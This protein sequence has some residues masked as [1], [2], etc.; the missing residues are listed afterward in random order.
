MLKGFLMRNG[1]S[2]LHATWLHGNRHPIWEECDRVDQLLVVNCF[3]SAAGW[4]VLETS[5]RAVLAK[6]P[7]AEIYLYLSMEGMGEVGGASLIDAIFGFLAC[8]SQISVDPRAT[9]QVWIVCDARRG[10][11]HPKGYALKAGSR[12]ITVVGSSNTTRAGQ[13]ENYEMEAQLSDPASFIDFVRA[14]EELK[15]SGTARR[16]NI[17]SSEQLRRFAGDKEQ[18]RRAFARIAGQAGFDNQRERAIRELQ[19]GPSSAVPLAVDLAKTL[20]DVRRAFRVGLRLIPHDMGIPTH[21]VSLQ[22]FVKAG[23]LA[24]PSPRDLHAGIMVSSQKRSPSVSANLAPGAIVDKIKRIKHRQAAVLGLFSI[25]MLGFR[26][27]PC[28]WEP[29]FKAHLEVCRASVGEIALEDVERH[30]KDISE[31]L[32][33]SDF[34]QRLATALPIVRNTARWNVE[35]INET[36]HA[37]VLMS[38]AKAPILLGKEDLYIVYGAI[39]DHV[40]A[41]VTDHLDI[42]HTRFQVEM[43]GAPPRSDDPPDLGRNDALD[44][45]ATMSELCCGGGGAGV[46]RVLSTW[47]APSPNLA[48]RLQD[49]VRRIRRSLMGRAELTCACP[50]SAHP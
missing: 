44:F 34:V 40:R 36:L 1:E 33:S 7:A 9:L 41:N 46:R 42:T 4:A 37:P 19:E 8:H 2:R 17:E 48:G 30:L 31:W 23:V 18:R 28:A 11:F 29:T 26:W 3:V 35:F 38:L 39:C 14:T 47:A 25:E 49:N 50:S 22:Q 5:L 21:S 15:T 13:G 32:S 10:L 24:S 43:A 16:F 12:H 20:E 27:L 45:V 6:N